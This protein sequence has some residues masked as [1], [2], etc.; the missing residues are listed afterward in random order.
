MTAIDTNI[1]LY[2]CD[3]TAGKRH[4]IAKEL[5]AKTDDGVLL[6]Q[7]ACE[8]VAASRKLR[9]KGLS[10][11]SAWNLPQSFRS[12]FPLVLPTARVLVLGRE[13]N[14]D[15][16]VSCW[17]TMILADCLDAGITTLISEDTSANA[18]GLEVSIVNPFV[19]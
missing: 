6:W 17:D 5:I 1:L 12:V 11:D 14:L 7:V 4:D 8:F 19:Q 9:D 13:I 10:V 15:R 2:A 16:Q 3:T 18:T